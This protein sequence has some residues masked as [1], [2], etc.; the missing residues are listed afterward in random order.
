VNNK[1]SCADA[2][3]ALK[4]HGLTAHAKVIAEILG[5]DS[6]AVATALRNAVDDGRVSRRYKRGLALYRFKRLTPNC[7]ISGS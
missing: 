4:K 3:M 6:R 2:V 1:I 7:G 5:T